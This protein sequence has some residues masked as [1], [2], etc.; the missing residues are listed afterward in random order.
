MRL[1]D[2]FLAVTPG[3][4]RDHGRARGPFEQCL[5]H[6]LAALAEMVAVVAEE[7]AIVFVGQLQP[8]E[9]VEHAPD[10]RIEKVIEVYTLVSPRAVLP[11]RRPN[12]PES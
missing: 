6:P 7:D 11:H 12:A 4:S 3:T 2:R 1:V 9:R 8:I 10:V 5:L